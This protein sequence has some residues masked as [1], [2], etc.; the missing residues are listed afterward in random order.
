MDGI[1]VG[2]EL[3]GVRNNY[4]K[5]WAKFLVRVRVRNT[6]YFQLYKYGYGF[7]TRTRTPGYGMTAIDNEIRPPPIVITYKCFGGS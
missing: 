1:R 7:R 3:R 4:G 2:F 5:K 6:G